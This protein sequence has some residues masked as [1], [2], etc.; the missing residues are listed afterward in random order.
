MKVYLTGRHGSETAFKI[1]TAQIHS[2]LDS[3]I[4]DA[5]ADYVERSHE[6]GWFHKESL[7]DYLL[8][9]GMPKA[10]VTE[11]DSG[12]VVKKLNKKMWK[13]II[14]DYASRKPDKLAKFELSKA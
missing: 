6:N 4:E 3:F 14:D 7:E 10:Y 13:E 12:Q 1:T 8:S 11:L 5:M 2:N 9:C